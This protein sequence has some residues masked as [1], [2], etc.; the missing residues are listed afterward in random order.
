MVST[1]EADAEFRRIFDD[2]YQGV[3]AYC[4]RRTNR[5][6]AEDAAAETFVV[7]WRRLS[8][9]P[10][11]EKE[12]S[13]LYGVAYRVLSH[14]WRSGRRYRRV[15]TRV[16]QRHDFAGW[17]LPET[18]VVQAAE[19][20]LVLAA[21]ARLKPKDQEVLRL[22][23]WEELSH[24]HIAELLGLTPA[25]VRQRFLR[26]KRHLA[27]EYRKMGGSDEGPIPGRRGEAHDV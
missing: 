8:A 6:D 19:Y 26:A 1:A 9:I 10:P 7:A 16:A 20:Q 5:A 24:A 25:T 17:G 12:R 3:L 27:T 15:L 22:A 11:G 23:M 4:L 14:Q 21:A 18:Q 13:W 2:H